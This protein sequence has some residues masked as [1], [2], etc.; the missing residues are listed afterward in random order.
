MR[1]EFRKNKCDFG[2]VAC[3]VTW[4]KTD[5][6]HPW[7][8]G[9]QD[10]SPLPVC[11]APCERYKLWCGDPA[12]HILWT[13]QPC[14]APVSCL[15]E[16]APRPPNSSASWVLVSPGREGRRGSWWKAGLPHGTWP[17]SMDGA[18]LKPGI[19]W[20]QIIISDVVS[21]QDSVWA[22]GSR[23]RCL[24]LPHSLITVWIKNS[25][26]YPGLEGCRG[27]GADRD[28]TGGPMVTLLQ[29]QG[30][31]HV[32]WILGSYFVLDTTCTL[33]RG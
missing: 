33:P 26:F 6:E 1:V 21:F 22:N 7:P 19:H 11:Q 3:S 25:V 2:H 14:L 18:S 9:W 8:L 28:D 15:T 12:H 30:E 10:A 17:G 32:L 16:A 24:S 29:V 20:R 23:H 5:P 31:Q 4:L 13:C 27:V